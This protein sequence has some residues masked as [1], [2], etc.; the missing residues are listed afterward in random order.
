MKKLLYPVQRIELDII[1]ISLV[2][3]IA[4]FFS[5][6][7][8][9]L[10]YNDLRQRNTAYTGMALIG[11]AAVFVILIVWENLLFSSQL[12]SVEDGV[13]VGNH[14]KKEILR[15]RTGVKIG[16]VFIGSN[17]VEGQKNA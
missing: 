14:A 17:G 8:F 11:I 4:S 15:S 1:V 3:L 5:N 12:R 13:K 6:Q 9:D 2:F 7:V 16:P 10:P